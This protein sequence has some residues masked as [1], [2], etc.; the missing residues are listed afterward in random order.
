MTAPAAR[1]VVDAHA[2][3]GEG[4]VWCERE[5]VLW[6]V[7]IDGNQLHRFDPASGLDQHWDLGEAV[8][9]VQLRDSGSPVLALKSGFAFFDPAT[10]QLDRLATPEAD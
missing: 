5:Q 3:T 2:T 9:C 1:L 8:A 10:G 6:W 7:D 4:P